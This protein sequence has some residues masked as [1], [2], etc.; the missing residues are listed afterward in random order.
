ATARSCGCRPW[1]RGERCSRAERRPAPRR[2]S[3]SAR[4]GARRVRRASG[5]GESQSG[6]PRDGQARLTP[7]SR[8]AWWVSPPTNRI[9]P[10][11]SLSGNAPHGIAA[12]FEPARAPYIGGC[13]REPCQLLTLLAQPGTRRS[14][15]PSGT[16]VRTTMAFDERLA[17]RIRAHL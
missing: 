13:E 6:G 8:S 9:A 10:A 12:R 1:S 11:V 5:R 4:A 17:E 15:C 2:G 14:H 16:L 3:P 7:G